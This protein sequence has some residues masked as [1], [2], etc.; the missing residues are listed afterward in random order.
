MAKIV[1]DLEKNKIHGTVD[2]DTIIGDQEF[3]ENDNV[4]GAND[5]LHGGS[6]GNDAIYGDVLTNTASFGETSEVIGGDDRIQ[7]ADGD[8]LVAGDALNNIA[9]YSG[10]DAKMIGGDDE[11]HGGDGDDTVV[12]DSVSNFT[13]SGT[14]EVI[15]GN[16]NIKGG[17]GD[18][19]L[20]GDVKN[21]YGTVAGGDDVLD[22]GAGNDTLVGD[23]E[24][25]YS[26]TVTG[27][28]DTFKFTAEDVSLGPDPYTDKIMDFHVAEGDVI[29]VSEM[30]NYDS[31]MHDIS[32]FIFVTDDGEGNAKLLFD[33]AG[34][35]TFDDHAI[36]LNG[37][38]PADV[39][40]E[41]LIA[42][43]NLVVEEVI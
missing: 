22:S 33:V 31:S 32:N 27:G 8:D 5:K 21:N 38:A 14:A 16:D 19:V 12:G 41:T 10:D 20:V 17:A 43:G 15:G 1:G 35:A 39:D 30:I 9:V 26:G 25:N 3:V 36:V 34:T 11:I 7:G 40:L 6:T 2:N 29:D 18:D 37:I 4:T 24:N 13:L 42:G 23:V 28:S